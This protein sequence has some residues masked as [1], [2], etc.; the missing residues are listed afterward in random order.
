MTQ[1]EILDEAR[2]I[3]SGLRRL[4]RDRKVALA[5]HQELKLNDELQVRTERLIGELEKLAGAPAPDES[6]PQNSG[7]S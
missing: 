1:K 2:A 5:I 4:G 7:N 6:K 3:L